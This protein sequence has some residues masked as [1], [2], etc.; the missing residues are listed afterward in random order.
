MEPIDLIQQERKLTAG[1]L[2]NYKSQLNTMVR[3][4]GS[5]WWD[6]DPKVTIEAIDKSGKSDTTKRSLYQICLVL[7]L[8]SVTHLTKLKEGTKYL[9]DLAYRDEVDKKLSEY[10]KNSE[11]FRKE[12]DALKKS[13]EKAHRESPDN[14]ISVNQKENM[15]SYE[16]LRDYIDRLKEDIGDSQELHRA[17][18]I[19]E[20]LIRVPVRN[21]HAGMIY[22]GKRDFMH[23]RIPGK[24]YL[25]DT[26][27]KKMTFSYYQANTTKTRP[28]EHQDLPKELESI[29]KAYIRK[30]GIK[31][32]DVI[33]PLSPNDLSHLLANTSKKYTGKRVSTTLIRKIV[34]GHKFSDPDFK[35]KKAEQNEFAKKM[36]HSV[37]VQDLVYNKA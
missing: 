35:K 36:G 33:V 17:Y 9:N 14:V 15:I 2:R 37:A 26:V 3:L 27:N 4:A 32:G 25:V 12:M 22:I 34:V 5:E 13:Y 10:K 21:D 19:L 30:W 23:E 18:V 29:W 31:K 28:D 24:N 1:T 16:E 11:L 8:S 20:S 6:N 7:M